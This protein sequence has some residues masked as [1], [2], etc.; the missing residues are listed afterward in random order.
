MGRATKLAMTNGIEKQAESKPSSDSGI[1]VQDVVAHDAQ[2][3]LAIGATSSDAL[4]TIGRAT[5]LYQSTMLPGR[6][7]LPSGDAAENLQMM[8]QDAAE[9]SP[10]KKEASCSQKPCDHRRRAR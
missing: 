5:D 1:L 8:S 6:K 4:K 7:R 9:L 3:S 2:T 10:P